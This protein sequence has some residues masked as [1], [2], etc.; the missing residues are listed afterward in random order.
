MVT[1]LGLSTVEAPWIRPVAGISDDIADVI[2]GVDS[3]F[4]WSCSAVDRG[5]GLRHKNRPIDYDLLTLK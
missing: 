2:R 4:R 3:E 5:D 1:V